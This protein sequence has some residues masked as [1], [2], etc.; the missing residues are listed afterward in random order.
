MLTEQQLLQELE[1]N[2]KQ[3]WWATECGYTER[4][5]DLINQRIHLLHTCIELLNKQ[6]QKQKKAA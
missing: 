6:L 3:L 5:K 2:K 4:M 1:N